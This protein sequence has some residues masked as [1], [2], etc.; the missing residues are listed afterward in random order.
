MRL[1]L[2]T[3]NF[4]ARKKNTILLQSVTGMKNK[5]LIGYKSPYQTFFN[6]FQVNTDFKK[7]IE[8]R[9]SK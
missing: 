6:I 8:Q 9:E 2:L 5:Q 3:F 1:I 4:I 7:C